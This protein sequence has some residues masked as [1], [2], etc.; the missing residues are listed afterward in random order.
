MDDLRAS[1]SKTSQSRTLNSPQD[2][3]SFDVKEDLG[4]SDADSDIEL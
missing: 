2:L 1:K 3:V 4:P